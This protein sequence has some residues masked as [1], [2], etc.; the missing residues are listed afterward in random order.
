MKA[1]AKTI[2]SLKDY[3]IFTMKDLEVGKHVQMHNW[4]EWVHCEIMRIDPKGSGKFI[5][6]LT[7]YFIKDWH[8]L[9]K[10]D[11][12]MAHFKNIERINNFSL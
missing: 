11:L 1:E 2:K 4:F 10:W 12:I 5:G 8:W 9:K 6:K 3:N 7:T